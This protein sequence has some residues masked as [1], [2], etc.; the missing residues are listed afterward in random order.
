MR[1]EPKYLY[2]LLLKEK[3]FINLRKIMVYYNKYNDLLNLA[4]GT[5]MPENIKEQLPPLKMPKYLEWVKKYII[6]DKT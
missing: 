6:R 2:L 4:N 3:K 1:R 5:D